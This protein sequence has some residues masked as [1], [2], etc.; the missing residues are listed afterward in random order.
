MTKL[1]HVS[2][3]PGKSEGK[4]LKMGEGGNTDMPLVTA[5]TS[6][7]FLPCHKLICTTCI[8]S[9]RCVS[10]LDFMNLSLGSS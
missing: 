4:Q 7:K 5:M 10:N 1:F 8:Y 3:F 2:I 6:S 9:I